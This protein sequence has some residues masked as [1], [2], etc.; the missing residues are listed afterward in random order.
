VD[1]TIQVL[2]VLLPIA[3]VALVWWDMRKVDLTPNKPE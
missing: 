3:L 2:T 1:T